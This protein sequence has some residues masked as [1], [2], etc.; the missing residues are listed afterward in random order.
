M[1]ARFTAWSRRADELMAHGEWVDGRL[2]YLE[3]EKL[4]PPG[5]A[6]RRSERAREGSVRCRVC[7][8]PRPA[9]H[10]GHTFT[11][12][13]RSRQRGTDFLIDIGKRL[14]LQSVV[15]ARVEDQAWEVEP[16]P[17]PENGWQTGAWRARD[18]RRTRASLTQLA[19]R[20][21]VSKPVV[22]QL[23]MADPPLP[24]ITRG[25]T[26]YYSDL[27]EFESRVRAHR[28]R[29]KAKRQESLTLAAQRKLA[30]RSTKVALSKLAQRSHITV[31]SA[32]QIAEGLTDL[33]WK[34][35]RR[36]WFLPVEHLPAWDAALAAWLA[37]R[38]E[39]HAA[40]SRLG[41]ANRRAKRELE[42]TPQFEDPEL[43]DTFAR[44]MAGEKNLKDDVYARMQEAYHRADAE[45][46]DA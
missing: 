11:P 35:G 15:H 18:L 2:L 8:A 19:S 32:R 28:E 33:P 13:E 10:Q 14:I 40:A 1:S 5:M 39:R 20:Y 23:V 4:I 43:T 17:I 30:D 16:W 12:G 41:A 26:T 45:A 29:S 38:P 42:A 24:S 36:V 7:G 9:T 31:R 37:G 27:P 6:Y 34:K 22:L 25:S 44:Y 21:R 46:G 3:M